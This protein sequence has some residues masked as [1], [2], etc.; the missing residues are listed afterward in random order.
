MYISRKREINFYKKTL[1]NTWNYKI[2]F[3]GIRRKNVKKITQNNKG[4]NNV[5]KIQSEDLGA[6]L[7]L[8]Q[9]FY[10]IFSFLFLSFD[11]RLLFYQEKNKE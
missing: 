7:K 9:L 6:A 1:K 4:N 2:Y 11:F 3:V 8:R 10:V 5:I